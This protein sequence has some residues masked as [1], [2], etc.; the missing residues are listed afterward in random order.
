MSN[1]YITHFVGCDLDYM[2][3]YSWWFVPSSRVSLTLY[4][5]FFIKLVLHICSYKVQLMFFFLDSRYYC[6]IQHWHWNCDFFGRRTKQVMLNFA[7]YG[8]IQ[9]RMLKYFSF[10]C[11][12]P[13]SSLFLSL[14]LPPLAFCLSCFWNLWW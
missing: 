2:F 6:K 1:G 7:I 5:F 9:D 11:N 12:N 13:L 14:S 3:H 10:L 4:I 8:I